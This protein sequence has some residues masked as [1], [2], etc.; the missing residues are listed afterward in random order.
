MVQLLVQVFWG[1]KPWYL[2]YSRVRDGYYN[3]PRGHSFLPVTH[4]I[5]PLYCPRWSWVLSPTSGHTKYK[6]TQ[7][8]SSL[9]QTVGLL[10][11]LHSEAGPVND[12]GDTKAKQ[13]LA[14]DRSGLSVYFTKRRKIQRRSSSTPETCSTT[15][16]RSAHGSRQTSL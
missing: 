11:S 12:R 1:R 15:E 2:C 8:S 6:Q 4:P 9:A 5:G 3:K 7:P 14:F 16:H 13:N 10:T